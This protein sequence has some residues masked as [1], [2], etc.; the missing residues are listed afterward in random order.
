GTTNIQ[1]TIDGGN[2]KFIFTGNNKDEFIIRS[3]GTFIM[4]PSTEGNLSSD[5]PTDSPD[6]PV[7]SGGIIEVH[8]TANIFS[9]GYFYGGNASVKFYKSTSLSGTAIAETHNGELHFFETLNVGGTAHL[10]ITCKRTLKVDGTTTLQSSGFLNAVSG[11][12]YLGGNLR[13]ESNSAVFNAG[14]STIYFYG[15][16]FE[17]EGY[18]N[19]ETSTFIFNASSTQIVSTHNYRENIT[20]YNL[21]AEGTAAVTATHNILVLND[22]IVEEHAEF[23]VTHGKTLNVVGV[24]TGDPHVDT[25]R[26]YIISIRINSPGSITA[27][28]NE[29]LN[30]NS[31][32][33]A[34]NYRIE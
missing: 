20:F 3:G 32:Q 27:I 14:S 8:T 9:S 2:G 23:N 15:T 26:P 21:I 19:A 4:S 13:T 34:K 10:N 1:G 18:F 6:N 7:P 11:T 29:P 33:N 31:A 25:N 16:T 24:V 30:K 17:N 28:F 12:I 22:M 5:C